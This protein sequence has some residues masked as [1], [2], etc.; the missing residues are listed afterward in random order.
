MGWC[1]CKYKGKHG[2]GLCEHSQSV[3]KVKTCHVLDRP[4]P[5]AMLK[6]CPLC[7]SCGC[8]QP[9]EEETLEDIQESGG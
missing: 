7:E 9:T 5:I 2:L 6:G 1:V 4:T 3:R 8:I